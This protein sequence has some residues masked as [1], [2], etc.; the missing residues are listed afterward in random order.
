MDEK[1]RREL[2]HFSAVW[3]RVTGEKQVKCTVKL[4]PRREK[5]VRPTLIFPK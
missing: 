2:S 5:R 1:F 3:E 4:M